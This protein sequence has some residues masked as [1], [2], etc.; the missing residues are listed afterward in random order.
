[1]RL[2]KVS[3]VAYL[4]KI[5]AISSDGLGKLYFTFE[6]T[7][8]KKLNPTGVLGYVLEKSP[9]NPQITGRDLELLTE[10]KLMK[11]RT[12]KKEQVV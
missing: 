5:S 4:P 1:M 6:K 8:K 9:L 7:N 12:K 11:Q 10:V 3:P 2:N